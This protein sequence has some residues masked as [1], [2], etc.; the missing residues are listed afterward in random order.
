VTAVAQHHIDPSPGISSPPHVSVIVLNHNGEKIIAKCIEHLLA[1]TYRDFE[2]VV[3]DNDSSDG[4]L[5]VMER[6]LGSGRL[7]IVRSGRNLGVAGGRNLGALHVQGAIIAFIDNDGFADPGWLAAA[8]KT[9]ESSS[10][11]GVVAS[12]VFFA[13]RKIV[14]NGAGGTVNRQGYGGDFCFDTPYEF[15]QVPDRV[16]YAMGCGM[17]VRKDV[18]DR[19]GPLDEKL[20][21]YYDDTEL[22]IRAW[23]SGYEVAVA[24]DAWID[25]GF[26]YTDKFFGNKVF[27][28]ERNRIRTVLK[29]FPMQRLP[30]WFAREMAYC[31]KLERK[32]LSIIV[33]AWA[34][35]FAH[36]PSALGLRARFT[37]RRRPF[38][39]L[40]DPSWGRFPPPTP[41]NQAIHPDPA[42]AKAILRLD[43]K[44]DAHQL[45]FGWYY[46]EADGPVVYRWTAAAASAWFRFRTPVRDCS[47]TFLGM[48]SQRR[49]RIVIRPLGSLEPAAKVTLPLAALGWQQKRFP[50]HLPAGEYELLLLPEDS[51][52]DGS[53]R[54]L[55]VAV[56]SVEFE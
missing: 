10:S 41:N 7:S 17:V 56:S 49:A 9:M 43:G 51:F 8:V 2:I 19:V 48:P 5:A 50:V 55:G 45:N 32:W 38:W 3:V 46:A 16:L 13:S 11:I 52:M 24:P 12:V 4:S 21:N 6:Y 36:L 53:G 54:R 14:L 30:A 42:R 20:F 15:A 1:Q 23:K 34:W 47:I 31:G 25:H 26:G 28:C 35:N 18:W 44:T 29:Y 40:L 37:M 22:G 27:L 33:R 39:H